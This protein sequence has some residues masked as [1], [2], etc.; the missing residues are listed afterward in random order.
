[1]TRNQL[2]YLAYI[3]MTIDHAG[4]ILFPHLLWMRVIGRLAAPIFFYFAAMAVFDTRDKKKYVLRLLGFALISEPF[5][6]QMVTGFWFS[7]LAQNVYFTI[8][9]GVLACISIRAM[10]NWIDGKAAGGGWL[11]AI[12]AVPYAA[13][14]YITR[15]DYRA[16]GVLLI[17]AFFCVRE[18]HLPEQLGNFMSLI[19]LLVVAMAQHSM[20]IQ[21]VSVFVGISLPPK[22][23][24]KRM[25]KLWYFFYPVHI[26]LLLF[27]KSFA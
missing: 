3:T 20:W 12:A 13:L 10:R 26:G 27:V 16:Y 18:F 24:G 21:A 9:L 6:D 7:S 25:S 22:P 1:M 19:C 17:A 23:S 11:A 14:A 8:L 15:T 2:K 5:F 4:H